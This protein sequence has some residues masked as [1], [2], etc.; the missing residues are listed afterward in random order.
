MSAGYEDGSPKL[1]S[2]LRAPGSAPPEQN[3]VSAHR[4]QPSRSGH[5]TLERIARCGAR[6]WLCVSQ[7]ASLDFCPAP[8]VEPRGEDLS[9]LSDARLRPLHNMRR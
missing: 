7:H 3:L 4:V 1:A 9:N 5:S 6:H 2:P 8:G